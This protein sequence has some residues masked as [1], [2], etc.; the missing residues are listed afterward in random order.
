LGG[1][2]HSTIST[3]PFVGADGIGGRGNPLAPPDSWQIPDDCCCV[4]SGDTEVAVGFTKV[5][6]FDV[7][8]TTIEDGVSVAISVVGVENKPGKMYKPTPPMSKIAPRNVANPLLV[9]SISTVP[10]VPR[11]NGIKRKIKPP[12]TN[13][14]GKGVSRRVLSNSIILYLL[15]TEQPTNG[16]A[17]RQRR[18]WQDSFPIIAPHLK[19]RSVRERSRSTPEGCEAAV[20]L[21]PRMMSGHHFLQQKQNCF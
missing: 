8:V 21:H 19:K 2:H 15:F 12:I 14:D 18:D 4:G 1:T 13:S 6:G 10:F 16:M 20:R 3:Q 7:A 9:V 5:T 17:Q 11:I